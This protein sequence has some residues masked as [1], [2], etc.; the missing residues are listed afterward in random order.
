MHY[1][2]YIAQIFLFSK[3]YQYISV[4]TKMVKLQVLHKNTAKRDLTS[5]NQERKSAFWKI[6][7]RKGKQNI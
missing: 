1:M 7:P 6:S 4:V 5:N 3:L 2:H